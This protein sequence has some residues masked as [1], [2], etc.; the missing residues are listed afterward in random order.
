MSTQIKIIRNKSFC[1][2]ATTCKIELDGTLVGQV[3]N[4]EHF[5]F[6]LNDGIHHFRFFDS[7]DKLLKSGTLT[8]N[9]EQDILIEIQF[10]GSTGKL[11]IFSA[12]VTC[13]IVVKTP[14]HTKKLIAFFA[15]VFI[16]AL[17]I[18]TGAMKLFSSPSSTP[19]SDSQIQYEFVDLQDMLNELDANALRAEEKYQDKYIEIIGVIKGFDSD[20][21]YISIVPC[22]SSGL[23]F[24]TVL[25]YITEP[26][27]KTFLLTKNVG[28]IVTIRCQVSSIGEILG[29]SVK[30]REILD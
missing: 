25:C 28:D 7:F 11:D 22:G 16:S 14:S 23:I 1:G 8:V 6:E 26:T 20:G 2:F 12:S 21:K 29:Y 4:G 13:D 30:I 18:Y 3:N 24:D 17:I 5:S 9:G 27:Q 15:V 19:N 10:N